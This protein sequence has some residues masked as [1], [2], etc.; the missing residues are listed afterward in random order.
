M[1]QNVVDLKTLRRLDN[2]KYHLIDAS[3]LHDMML[4]RGFRQPHRKDEPNATMLGT[5]SGVSPA[6][7]KR[8]LKLE[9]KK[10]MADHAIKIAIRLFCGPRIRKEHQGDCAPSEK[11]YYAMLLAISREDESHPDPPV[12]RPNPFAAAIAILQRG[13]DALKNYLAQAISAPENAKFR[14]PAIVSGSNDDRRDVLVAIDEA[15]RVLVAAGSNQDDTVNSVEKLLVAVVAARNDYNCAA[16]IREVRLAKYERE[17]AKSAKL[18]GSTGF[19]RSTLIQFTEDCIAD[20]DYA[21]AL[22]LSEE[23]DLARAFGARYKEHGTLLA[24]MQG[25][26]T[27]L[28]DL[29]QKLNNTINEDIEFSD[30]LHMRLADTHWATMRDT[31]EAV[32]RATNSVEISLGID[33][34]MTTGVNWLKWSAQWSL[35]NPTPTTFGRFS[36]GDEVAEALMKMEQAIRSILAEQTR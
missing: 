35:R 5:D 23:A 28:Q 21:D 27:E 26:I 11:Q 30:A 6:T 34:G 32:S 13:L 14:G 24:N 9:T 20:A 16:S 2:L 18:S 33:G 22:G 4:K 15:R 1:D 29:K 25:V 17:R 7:I 3:K 10:T 31:L 19:S 8:I 12:P 36:G